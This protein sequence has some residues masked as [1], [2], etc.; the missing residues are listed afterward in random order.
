[1]GLGSPRPQGPVRGPVSRGGSRGGSRS[2]CRWRSEAR[3]EHE[4]GG[5]GRAS[6]RGAQQGQRAAAAAADL[7]ALEEPALLLHEVVLELGGLELHVLA[8]VANLDLALVA[9]EALH[10]LARVEELHGAGWTWR[11]LPRGVAPDLLSCPPS[12]GPLTS[13]DSCINTQLTSPSIPG[14]GCHGWVPVTLVGRRSSAG[15]ARPCRRHLAMRHAGV[16]QAP[17]LVLSRGMPGCCSNAKA[18]GD[19]RVWRVAGGR[20]MQAGARSSGNM[21]R[22]ADGRPVQAARVPRHK[23]LY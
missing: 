20:S 5:T 14:D 2:G 8:P 21:W 10:L 15:R 16:G 12:S 23:R 18:R 22:A 4:R 6:H 9:L 7:G 3:K 17:L 1:M 11:V 19:A 13:N